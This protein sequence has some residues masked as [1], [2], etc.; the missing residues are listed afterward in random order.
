MHLRVISKRSAENPE[1]VE[2]KQVYLNAFGQDLRL[3]L[4]PNRQFN[5]KLKSMKLFAAE[6]SSEGRLKYVEEPIDLDSLGK[7]YHDDNNMAAVVV[8]RSNDGKLLMV[9][10][11]TFLHILLLFST[12]TL[13][14][15]FSFPFN[16]FICVTAVVVVFTASSSFSER[17]C[18]S[19]FKSESLFNV[20]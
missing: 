3:N 8:H 1:D 15:I 19:S 6:T 10:T 20:E 5:S 11:K 13:L 2:H 4:R 7:S 17:T 14:H 16:D 18:I 9:S 12:T